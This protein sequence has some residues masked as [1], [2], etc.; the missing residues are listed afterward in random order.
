MSREDVIKGEDLVELVDEAARQISGEILPWDDKTR[1]RMV[2]MMPEAFLIFF[3]GRRPNDGQSHLMPE[4]VREHQ[5]LFAGTG[6]PLRCAI[7]PY[8]QR[9]RGGSG[10]GGVPESVG[11]A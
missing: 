9:R 8:S 11:A 3:D 4:I 6:R 5:V 10:S 2:R 7:D 1:F